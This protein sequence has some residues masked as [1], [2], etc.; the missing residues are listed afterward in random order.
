MEVLEGSETNVN[1]VNTTGTQDNASIAVDHFGKHV[2][3][4]ADAN[5]GDI[6]AQRFDSSG[7][8]L[9]TEF[10]VNTTTTGNQALSANA[11]AVSFLDNGDFVVVWESDHGGTNDVYMQL[12]NNIGDPIGSETIV[13][14][15]T[16]NE[17]SHASVAGLENGGYVVAWTGGSGTYDTFI[18]VYSQDGTGGSELQ[19]NTG[20]A[21]SSSASSPQVAALA[22]GGFVVTWSTGDTTDDDVYAEIYDDQG[23]VVTAEFQVNTTTTNVQDEVSVA[24]LD[25]GG[26]VVVW[27]TDDTGDFDING[28]RYDASGTAVGSEFTVNTTT[29]NSQDIPEVA[30]LEDGGW[31]VTWTADTAQDGTGTGIYAQRYNSDGTTNGSEFLINTLTTGDESD[32]AIATVPDGGFVVAYHSTEADGTTNTGVLSKVFYIGASSSDQFASHNGTAG[33]DAYIGS[34]L[35]D[36]IDS[37]AGD[38]EIYGMAGNDVLTG[39]DGND[40]IQGGPGDDTIDGGAGD[41]LLYG[42][43]GADILTGGTGSDRFFFDAQTGSSTVMDFTSGTDKLIIDHSLLGDSDVVFEQLSATTYDGTNAT[44][45]NANIIV[46]DQG[47]VYHDS[48]GNA[49]GGYTLIGNLSGAPTVASDDVEKS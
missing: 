36:V 17:Q 7:A 15:T 8:K 39:G 37:L 22:N 5:S 31:L 11:N 46:D 12:F 23:N 41:D 48:N 28:Q 24:A 20:A 25:D 45:P 21:A 35:A 2:I 1:T 32:S 14:V 10:A 47:D 49:S 30:A 40:L 16:A 3:V 27:A 44:N 26:F 4:F 43:S 33:N 13:N 6:I 29:T 9:G 42:E 18:R 38:D 19:V 34:I